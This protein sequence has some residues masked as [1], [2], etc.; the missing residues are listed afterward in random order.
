MPEMQ[1]LGQS[2][3]REEGMCIVCLPVYPFLNSYFI[4]TVAVSVELEV[5]KIT[6]IVNDVAAVILFISKTTMYVLVSQ[7]VVLD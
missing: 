6:F 4:V 1:I 3:E 5:V 7:F 2:W